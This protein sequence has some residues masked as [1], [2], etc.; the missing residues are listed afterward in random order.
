MIFFINEHVRHQIFRMKN[1]ELLT[2]GFF[3]ER[4]CRELVSFSVRRIECRFNGGGR[5]V[6]LDDR[7][8]ALIAFSFVERCCDCRR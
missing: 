4:G 2:S 7:F 3:F 1:T 5:V 8:V 6:K